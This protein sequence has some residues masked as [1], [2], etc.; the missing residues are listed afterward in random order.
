MKPKRRKK[1]ISRVPYSR[2]CKQ[3]EKEIRKLFRECNR[4]AQQ[5]AWERLKKALEELEKNKQ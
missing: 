4:E 5:R 1:H 3:G 2:L